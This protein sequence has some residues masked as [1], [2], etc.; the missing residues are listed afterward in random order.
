MS[1]I[2]HL[3]HREHHP[4]HANEALAQLE[5]APLHV[6]IVRAVVE[7]Q[8]LEAVDLVVERLH[9]SEVTV[10]DVVEQ[11]PEQERDAVLSHLGRLVPARD[12]ALDVIALVFADG[13]Q[14]LCGDECTEFRSRQRA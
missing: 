14:R 9:D 8:V 2:D 12:H 3:A 4:A 13:H 6:G 11:S 10:D 7:E 5:R 1:E